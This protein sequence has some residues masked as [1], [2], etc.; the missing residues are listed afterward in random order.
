[1][2]DALLRLQNRCKR[3]L[4]T[5]VNAVFSTSGGE[6]HI[7][8]TEGDLAGAIKVGIVVMPVAIQISPCVFW[9]DNICQ[10]QVVVSSKN[11]LTLL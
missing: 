6:K 1:V 10:N 7:A 2:P 3:Q 9:R 11:P 5:G 8:D 4:A